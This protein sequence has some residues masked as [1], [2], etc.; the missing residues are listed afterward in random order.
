MLNIYKSTEN[1]LITLTEIEQDCWV[2]VISP[3]AHDLERLRS[4]KIPPQFLSQL[5]DTDERARAEHLDK[6]VLIVLRFSHFQGA[7]AAIPFIT[8]P[9]SVIFTES[10]LV[11]ISPY[12]IPFLDKLATHQGAELS[13]SN[14]PHF[15]LHMLWLI[16]DAYLS[17]LRQINAQV[18]IL[19]DKLQR[20]LQNREV[21]ELLK[22]QKSLVH[23]K[24]A[25]KSNELILERLQKDKWLQP[26][27]QD[28][29]LL[30]DALIEFR[31]AIEVTAISENI[32]SQM[33][34]AFAS[35]IS[36]NLNVVMKI[37]ASVTIV[38]SLPTLVA[39]IYGMN[40]P[41]P[42]EENPSALIVILGVSLLLSSLV[43]VFF[44]KK[45]WL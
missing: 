16:A 9:L 36:N 8:A 30:A 21:L 27:A 14:R 26:Q 18:D 17:D 23:F 22:Y 38:L 44:R 29:D 40:I 33:M 32:L 10:F 15:I 41:L 45:G 24:T 2:R 43:I 39:S 42:G 25:L 1:G 34:D 37:L 13:P 35:I 28:G 6:A 31:Q 19:E 20:A 11:T 12:P 5:H 7:H 4:L 3:G